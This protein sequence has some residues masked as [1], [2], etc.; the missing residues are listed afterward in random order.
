MLQIALQHW[1]PIAAQD[2]AGHLSPNLQWCGL[3]TFAHYPCQALGG[4]SSDAVTLFHPIWRPAF[5]KS[6]FALALPYREKGRESEQRGGGGARRL[7]PKPND[8]GSGSPQDQWADT[9]DVQEDQCN[10]KT[11]QPEY[12]HWNVNVN[13]GTECP[14]TRPQETNK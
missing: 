9:R 1:A 10:Y 6:H 5:R 14:I 11:S 7:A 13:H 12:N 8:V 3:L 2:I 4:R